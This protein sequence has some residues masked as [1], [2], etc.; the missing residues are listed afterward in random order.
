MYAEKCNCHAEITSRYRVFFSRPL[1][2]I[3]SFTVGAAYISTPVVNR[4]YAP[5]TKQTMDAVRS[6]SSSPDDSATSEV[7]S[8]AMDTPCRKSV[9]SSVLKT[10]KRVPQRAGF[11]PTR[12]NPI[13]FQVQRLNRSAIV[14]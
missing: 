7:S 3:L 6:D 8:I 14:A 9:V 12:G 11:E 13:G 5:T 1:T 4:N 10:P 2:H